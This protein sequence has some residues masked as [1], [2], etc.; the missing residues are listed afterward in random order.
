LQDLQ[1]FLSLEIHQDINQLYQVGYTYIVVH[2]QIICAI[3]AA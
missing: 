1:P 3:M 2:C